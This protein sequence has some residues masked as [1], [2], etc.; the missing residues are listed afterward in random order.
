MATKGD[1]GSISP[2]G[3]WQSKS[4]GRAVLRRTKGS[5]SYDWYFDKCIM[6]KDELTGYIPKRLDAEFRELLE[7]W[8]QFDDG[9][10]IMRFF[11]W[12]FLVAYILELAYSTVAS[13][14]LSPQAFFWYLFLG[15]VV[16]QIAYFLLD[17]WLLRKLRTI[18]IHTRCNL[19]Q[20]LYFLLWLRSKKSRLNPFWPRRRLFYKGD[21]V[22]PAFVRD[23]L[24]RT[25]AVAK[26]LRPDQ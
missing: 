3:Y 1:S 15:L 4:P 18:R 20:Q 12:P 2:N 26:M 23:R 21:S 6:M 14:A 25:D 8:H 5:N 13:S 10:R 24:R 19:V 16:P 7:W 11:L 9:W 17:R 22:I